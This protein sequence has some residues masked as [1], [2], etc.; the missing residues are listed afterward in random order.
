MP[1]KKQPTNTQT[2]SAQ[3]QLPSSLACIIPSFLYLAPVSST[4]S[5]PALALKSLGITHILSIGKSPLYLDEEI[6]Y[7]RLSLLDSEDG[8]IIPVIDKS[9]DFIDMVEKENGK[10]LVH[11]SAAISRSPAVVIGYMVKRRG[12][13][14]GEALGLVKGARGVVSPNKGFLR[15]LEMLDGEMGGEGKKGEVRPPG[16]GRVWAAALS[17]LSQKDTQR[18][19]LAKT[20]RSNPRKMLKE[21]LKAAN[22]KKDE[23]MKKRWKVVIKGCTIILRDVLDKITV[24]VSKLMKIRDTIVQ[25]DPVCAAL[26][27]AAVRFILQ[28]AVND[29]ETFDFVPQSLENIA[30]FIA[31]FG[32]FE[33]RYLD[34]KLSATPTFDNLSASLITLYASILEYLT[35]ILH[36]FSQHSVV[37]LLKGVGSSVA[38]LEATFAPIETSRQTETVKQVDREVTAGFESLSA[39]LKNLEAPISRTTIS[40]SNIQDHLDRKTRARI[41]KSISAMPYSIHHKNVGKDR[42]D[43]SGQWL[44]ER[45]EYKSWRNDSCS[46]VLWLHGIPGS[47]KTNLASLVIDKVSEDDN[48]ASFYCM[49]NPAEPDRGRGDKFLAC[50]VRQLAGGTREKPILSAV[51]AQYKDT[52]QEIVEFEDHAWTKDESLRILELMGE[53][54]SATLVI[55]GLDEIN[56]KDQPEDSPNLFK[57][58]VSSRDNIDIALRLEGQP[59]VYVDA[60]ENAD[61]ISAFIENRIESARFLHGKASKQLKTSIAETLRDGA[62]GMFLWVDLQIQSLRPLKVAA[63]IEARLGVLPATLEGSYWQIYQDILASG[64]YSAELAI[65]T[66]QWLMYAKTS[67]P[68]EAFAL[69]ASSALQ[70]PEPKVHHVNS[71]YELRKEGTLATCLK[72]FLRPVDTSSH[73]TTQKFIVWSRWVRIGEPSR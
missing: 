46:S 36:R 23:S 55:D 73:K 58:L 47:G 51:K 1:K 11:C 70:E 49:R 69:I 37:R 66:F 44:L 9:C 29:V 26:P 57:I 72:A 56:E 14:L 43:G 42:L 60:E 4:S 59:N 15:R 3:P 41:L 31:Y 22:D 40:L 17:R 34:Q 5:K 39:A 25:Y 28:A 30:N 21:V 27:W 45:P 35:E 48:L 10:V 61:D 20:S 18:F 64:D 52:I 7:L 71:S 63:D 8:D 12:M 19:D 2:N 32:V 68:I 53:Y 62:Q 13:K 6:T 38:D 67:I 16:K 33:L 24:W 65:L 54:P 50:M